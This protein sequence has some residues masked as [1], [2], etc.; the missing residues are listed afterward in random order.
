MEATRGDF[1]NGDR[2]ALSSFFPS[3]ARRADRCDCSRATR[4]AFF[5]ALVC[6][7]FLLPVGASERRDCAAIVAICLRVGEVGAPRRLI[8][9]TGPTPS[10][11]YREPTCRQVIYRCGVG[12][13]LNVRDNFLL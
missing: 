9:V 11:R 7:A 10:G 8:G 5:C 2:G 1:F 4:A 3:A 6:R 13:Q 12:A